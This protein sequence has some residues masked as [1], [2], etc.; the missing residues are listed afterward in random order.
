MP[1][2]SMP[3]YRADAPMGPAP[4]WYLDPRGLQ[5]LRWWDGAR[6]GPQTQP[7][8][9]VIRDPQ[10]PGPHGQ[11][12]GAGRYGPFSD[13]NAGTRQPVQHWQPHTGA[14][15]PDLPPE[16]RSGPGHSARRAVRSKR[17][18]VRN[19]ILIA[20]GGL[21]ILFVIAGMIGAHSRSKPPASA[22]PAAATARA[23]ASPRA[24]S[25]TTTMSDRV[26]A[27]VAGP[28]GTALDGLMSALSPVQ[29]AA[30]SE[31]ISPTGSACSQLARAVT[32]AEAAPPIPDPAAQ[33]WYA[34]ALVQYEQAAAYC[35]AGV[36]SMNTAS[37]EKA[38]A[39][40]DAGNTD[41]AHTMAAVNALSS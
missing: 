28:G 24:S 15:S 14:Y 25:T 3:G 39:A 19:T 11:V 40:I 4:G 21:V 18:R 12:T 5:V 38:T 1:D 35:Q 37:I 34:R 2:P 32:T 7:L 41:I 6:W 16:P 33:K 29:P 36:S 30:Q 26:I 31:N 9:G 10:P 22:N 23:S 13:Q 17:H 8:P 20:T 27:W